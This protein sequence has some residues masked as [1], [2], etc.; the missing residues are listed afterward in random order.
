MSLININIKITYSFQ[1]SLLQ[2]YFP[3]IGFLLMI[4]YSSF[5]VKIGGNLQKDSLYHLSSGIVCMYWMIF[6]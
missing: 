3:N 6:K 4:E 2:T 5:L 1:I